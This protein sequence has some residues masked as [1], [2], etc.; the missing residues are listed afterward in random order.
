VASIRVFQTVLP[1]FFVA[2]SGREGPGE[3]G[4]FQGVLG[5]LLLLFTSYLRSS[6]A[7]CFYLREDGYATGCLM[8]M[9][10]K[11]GCQILWNWS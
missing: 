2:C 7:G 11:R 10:A 1:V 5:T 8:P 4:R 6:P 3:S 9:E